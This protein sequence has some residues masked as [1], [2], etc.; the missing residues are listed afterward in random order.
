MFSHTNLA[1]STQLRLDCLEL[2]LALLRNRYLI[3]SLWGT[4]WGQF[5]ARA[6]GERKRNV[7]LVFNVSVEWETQTFLDFW[8]ACHENVKS[9][10]SRLVRYSLVLSKLR[11][12][13][14]HVSSA[15]CDLESSDFILKKLTQLTKPQHNSKLPEQSLDSIYPEVPIMMVPRSNHKFISTWGHV[16]ACDPLKPLLKRN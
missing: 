14:L 16:S 4:T 1:K 7:F 15:R 10:I 6:V 11:S 13:W 9:S 12:T 3:T 5:M 8:Q 2:Y